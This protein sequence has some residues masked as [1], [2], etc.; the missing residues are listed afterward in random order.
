MNALIETEGVVGTSGS[1]QFFKMQNVGLKLN[2]LLVHF[3]LLLF[4][5]PPISNFSPLEDY[6]CNLFLDLGI[7][8]SKKICLSP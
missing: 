4:F 6:Y 1:A 2:F 7:W 3:F 8:N 5:L